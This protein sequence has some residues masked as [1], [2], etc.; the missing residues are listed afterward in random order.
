MSIKIETVKTDTFEMDYFRF[1]TGKTPFV[2]LP[3]LSVKSIMNSA[4]SIAVVYK[5]F[6]EDFTVYCFERTKFLNENYTIE[7]LAD[8]TAGQGG[9][10]SAG[11]S[12]Q[13]DQT[14]PY[15]GSF[16]KF[17]LIV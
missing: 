12:I 10:R 7:M 2:M 3:G 13:P 17:F 6:A 11:K 8:D 1:G 5:I 9:Q 15:G 16:R 14:V 4:D